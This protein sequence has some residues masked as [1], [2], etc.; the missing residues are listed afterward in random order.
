MTTLSSVQR[1]LIVSL[2]VLGIFITMFIWSEQ[3]HEV[4]GREF[5]LLVSGGGIVLALLDV[6]AHTGTGIGRRV[7]MVLSGSAHMT[8]D[9]LIVGVRRELIAIG[10][11][12]V[13]TA[14]MVLF[15]FVVGIPVYVFGYS[16]AAC[17]TD[18]APEHHRRHRHHRRDLDRLRAA[19]ELPSLSGHAVCELTI[20][21]LTPSGGQDSGQG[22]PD[23][24][25]SPRR[26]PCAD[27]IRGI[28]E[29]P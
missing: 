28:V 27:R 1:N 25:G 3:I 2:I 10:W 7:G 8:E 26:R 6:I 17:G 29:L 15:G 9:G 13:A 18:R 21:P 14:L 5:P 24:A 22:L 20:L 23:C 4:R 11:I 16:I 19:A 12:V